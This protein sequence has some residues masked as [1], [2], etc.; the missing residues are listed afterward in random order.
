MKKYIIY[1]VVAYIWGM[2]LQ[3][4]VEFLVRGMSFGDLFTKYNVPGYC[5]AG[6][7]FAV[8]MTSIEY[9]IERR[10]MKK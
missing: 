10:R 2:L 5:L 8:L 3:V 1:F 6:L 9:F 4:L 7:I